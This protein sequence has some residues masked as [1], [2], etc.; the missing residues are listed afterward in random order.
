MWK[1]RITHKENL[2]PSYLEQPTEMAFKA[3][4]GWGIQTAW[5][6]AQ[7]RR[8]QCK[9]LYMQLHGSAQRLVSTQEAWT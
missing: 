8:I 2:S 4:A 1:D 5:P 3:D 9:I 7:E 6:C